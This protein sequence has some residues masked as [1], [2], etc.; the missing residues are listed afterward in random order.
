MYCFRI[1]IA[2]MLMFAVKPVFTNTVWECEQQELVLDAGMMR[3]T[4][5][6]EFVSGRDVIYRV[7]SYMPPHPASYVNA[8]GTI[9]TNPGWTSD[10][11]KRGKYK[12]SRG[13][14]TIT[15]EDY[16]AMELKYQKD[17]LVSEKEEYDG[18]RMIF[19]PRK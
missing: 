5:T 17:A 14:L 7:H 15:F 9:D 4:N 10:W 12:Y 13:K 16:P 3:V 6:L 18:S 2:A 19:L 11:E 1:I 8:D